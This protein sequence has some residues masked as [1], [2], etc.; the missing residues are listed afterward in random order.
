MANTTLTKFPAGQAQYKI[1]FDYLARPFVVVTLVNSNDASKNRVLSAGSDYR[2][3][4]QTTVEILASQSGFDIVQLHRYTQ[5]DLVVDFRDGSVLTSKDLTEAGIQAIHIAEE[6][7]DQ[8]VD[9]AREYAD[10]AGVSAGNAKYSE[11]EARRIAESIKSAGLMGYITRRSFELGFTIQEWNEVL[12]WEADGDHYRWGGSLPKIV[13]AGSTPDT[14]G[15]IGTGKWVSV[16]DAALRS[17]LASHD[18]GDRLVASKPFPDSAARTQ[19]DQNK[20]FIS[21]RQ[22]LTGSETDHTSAFLAAQAASPSGFFVQAGTYTVNA[23]ISAPLVTYGSVKLVGTGSWNVVDLSQPI[24]D[25]ST[26]LNGRRAAQVFQLTPPTSIPAGKSTVSQGLMIDEQAGTYY[27][28]W[29]D[30]DGNAI[31]RQFDAGGKTLKEYTLPGV[32]HCDSISKV[33]RNGVT[34]YLIGGSHSNGQKI[35]ILTNDE[36]SQI[37]PT[38]N[39]EGV[40]GNLVAVDQYDYS[41]VAIYYRDATGQAWIT[42][43]IP[44]SDVF[45][46]TIAPDMAKKFRVNLGSD[47]VRDINFQSLGYYRGEFIIWAGNDSR[48]GQKNLYRFN[49]YGEMLEVMDVQVDRIY[50]DVEGNITEPE[51]LSLN[52]NPNTNEC[53]IYLTKCF[54]TH[55]ASIIRIYKMIKGGEAGSQF[56]GMSMRAGAG[57]IPTRVVTLPMIFEKSPGGWSVN[58][59]GTIAENGLMYVRNIVIDK[60]GVQGLYFDLHKPYVSIVGFSLTASAGL[61]GQRI[62]PCWTVHKG[63]SD[64]HLNQKVTFYDHNNNVFVSANDARISNGTM[65]CLELRVAYG[66]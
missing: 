61:L 65:F 9:L 6:G 14:S 7:R 16:G 42:Y 21:I 60:S 38:N 32:G 28:S 4:N 23:A 45:N 18:F 5:A 35:I 59:G 1:N 22:F 48:S 66:K 19:H 56:E 27:C 10:A 26:M 29:D 47:A 50:A 53:D 36:I 52:R 24:P 55:A 49:K 51:G 44:V 41:R 64:S 25:G 8:T 37:V 40:G 13:P 43:D 39:P 54:G 30:G 15:G 12:L 11:D 57:A 34:S 33:V 20:D 63:G 58:V 3:I 17:D 31:I 2:F 62:Q 46:N